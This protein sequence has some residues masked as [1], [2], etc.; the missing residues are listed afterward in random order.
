MTT[1]RAGPACFGLDEFQGQA[2]F[3]ER[4]LVRDQFRA[5]AAM[6]DMAGLAGLAA[7]LPVDMK[8]MQIFV[9][10]PEPGSI[11][12]GGISQQ[13]A[14]MA[15]EA[16]LKLGVAVGNIEFGRVI[17]D[18]ELVIL[19]AVRIMAG[20]A[21]PVPYGAVEHGHVLGQDP[22]VAVEA[23]VLAEFRQELCHIARMRGMAGRAAPL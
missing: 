21:L 16:K 15:A 3:A 9:P 11:G 7:V 14:V 2:P 12:G 10:I 5:L 22:L 13:V 6:D 17:S 4:D 23:E 8:I 19:R 1:R 20:S 18:Q